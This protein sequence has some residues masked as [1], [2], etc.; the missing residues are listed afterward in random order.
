SD[1]LALF[2]S[3][4]MYRELRVPLEFQPQAQVGAMFTIKPLLPLLLEGAHFYVL[5][6]GHRQP[7]LLLGTR[8][9]VTAVQ[10][11][12]LPES[13]D[14]AL[15]YDDQARAQQGQTPVE[16]QGKQASER[17]ALFHGQGG[18]YDGWRKVDL[19][20]YFHL[21]DDALRPLLADQHAPLVVAA[22]EY[23]RPIWR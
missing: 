20:R 8:D 11:P 21:V 16:K 18:D 5:V 14:A 13:I 2:L 6:L 10:V 4:Q 15:R 3:P 17:F 12:D 7:R 22:V 1:G 23:L 9:T 19:L